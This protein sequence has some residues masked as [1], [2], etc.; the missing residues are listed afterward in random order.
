MYFTKRFLSKYDRN[1]KEK[2][3][4]NIDRVLNSHQIPVHPQRRKVYVRL[5]QAEG[6]I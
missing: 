2:K 1:E 6:T 5:Q 3:N 4:L